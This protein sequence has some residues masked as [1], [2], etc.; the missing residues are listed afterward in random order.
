[1]MVK[2]SKNKFIVPQLQ[3]VWTSIFRMLNILLIY[4][5]LTHHDGNF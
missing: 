2:L 4:L 5:L 1:M 3:S